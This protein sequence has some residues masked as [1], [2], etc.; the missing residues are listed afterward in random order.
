MS[1]DEAHLKELIRRVKAESEV[2]LCQF[3]FELRDD[4]LYFTCDRECGRCGSGC[5][6][7]LLRDR[8]KAD[9]ERLPMNVYV[10]RRRG[11]SS[12]Y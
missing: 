7:Q 9:D 5:T 12:L 11:R 6:L 3:A 8:S 4:R 2:D 1:I 10:E